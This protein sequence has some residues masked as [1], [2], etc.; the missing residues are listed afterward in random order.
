MN[1]ADM[2]RTGRSHIKTLAWA[3]TLLSG[4]GGAAEQ[5]PEPKP[6]TP[7]PVKVVEKPKTE[8]ERLRD[9]CD[10]NLMTARAARDAIVARTGAERTLDVTMADLNRLQTALSNAEAE[11]SLWR[12]VHPDKAMRD[13]A[14]TC[15]QDVAALSTRLTL[16]RAL[17]EVFS[18]FGAVKA[19][20]LVSR[21][22]AKTLLD[23]RRAGVDKDEATR[24]RIKELNDAIVKTGQAFSKTITEDRRTVA[25]D[26]KAL[27]GLP[28]DWKAAHAPGKDGKVV[29]STDY[30]DY[31][32]FMNYSDDDD[33]RRQLYLVYRQRGTPTNDAH[34]K[35]L[36]ALRYELATILGYP[37]WAAFITEDKMI[38]TADKAAD[39]ISR[40]GKIADK[41]MKKER[42]EM[43][44]ALRKVN[45]KAR[46][47]QDWQQGWLT[48]RLK[49]AKFGYDAQ[50]MRPYLHY[51]K[52]RD[53]LLALTSDLFGVRYVAVKDAP[54]WDPDVSVYDVFEGDAKL[55]RIYLDMHPR[56]N[57]YKHAAQFTLK[58][59]VAGVQLP[60][61]VLVCNFPN[62]RTGNG[63]MEHKQVQTF[64]HEFGHLT[65]HILGGQRKWLRFSGVA[66]EWDFVEAPSQIFEEWATDYETLKPF[67]VNDKG[68]AVPE[69]LVEQMRAAKEFGKALWVRHQ[70]FYAAISLGLHNRN[71]EGLDLDKFVAE[72]MAE[73][74]PYPFVPDTH[75][76]N[77]FGHLNGYSAI[78]YTYMW[79]LVIAKDLFS[80][81]E[82]A[83]ILDKATAMRYRKTILDPG[84]SKDAADLV[85]DFLKR[86]YGFDAFQRWLSK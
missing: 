51:T 19:D 79:S 82:A 84:G 78:Y 57:K 52:V 11:S 17:Y 56:E 21:L 4:C 10:A 53:G 86:D 2:S 50:A 74:S 81:F 20:P 66:T 60:E 3:L 75:M 64:F 26:P 39:F 14:A 5:V 49:K 36:L 28:E 77:S 73:F 46:K 63:L 61:G 23:F 41:R 83:G 42:K 29:I 13:V 72:R 80:S 44:S 62:P 8:S 65:H 48:A 27:D 32:P 76:Q 25:L 24:K 38:K 7:A 12:S 31:I 18:S 85:T 16:D 58:A 35:K 6:A 68:E 30:P 47:V 71:P 1:V 9:R 15:E 59:G 70:M 54:V 37:S 34:L 22:L 69:K 55:G 33:A 43:L 40:I 67:A 45:R